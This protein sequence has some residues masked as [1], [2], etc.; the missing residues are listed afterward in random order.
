[1]RDVLLHLST[2][3][4]SMPT[5]DSESDLLDLFLSKYPTDLV[6][7]YQYFNDRNDLIEWMSNFPKSDIQVTETDGDPKISVIVPTIDSNSKF[8]D[9]CRNYLFKSLRIIFVE[10]GKEGYFNLS[11]A[12]N[13]G[14]KEALKSKPEW[15]VV[16]N[17][18]MAAIDSPEVL[19]KQL[20]QIEKN[21]SMFI[22][23]SSKTSGYKKALGK[24]VLPVP[25]LLSLLNRYELT[26]HNL[27][28]KFGVH[29][30]MIGQSSD[31]YSKFFATRYYLPIIGDFGIFNS[32]LFSSNK[33]EFFDQNFL[34]GVEDLDLSLR[35][36]L[37]GIS[38]KYIDYRI[39]GIGKQTQGTGWSRWLRDIS[40]F[41]YLNYKLENN[42][43]QI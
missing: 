12:Y 41:A 1:M 36:H 24:W 17:D 3:G 8:A 21:D 14:I 20:E 33:G 9:N 39:E 29:L 7:F 5:S 2:I 43:M 22:L 40:N 18:D 34:A 16:S 6:K 28:K 42:K 32:R 25:I 10:S 19:V 35:L 30:K 27:E 13:E 4:L 38:P 11:R 26:R 23:P 15:I 37:K 31:F